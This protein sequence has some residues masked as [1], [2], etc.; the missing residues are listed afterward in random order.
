MPDCQLS[1][2][3]LYWRASWVDREMLERTPEVSYPAVDLEY[4]SGSQYM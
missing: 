4:S 2:H 1:L 3:K